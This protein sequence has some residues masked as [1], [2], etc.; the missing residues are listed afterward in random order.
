MW[1]DSLSLTLGHPA[2]IHTQGSISIRALPCGQQCRHR[3]ELEGEMCQY[4]VE[5][6]E[7][8]PKTRL[9][10]KLYIPENDNPAVTVERKSLSS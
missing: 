2:T 4:Y 8:K 1:V 7:R 3:G 6:L 10:S 5:V 9:P